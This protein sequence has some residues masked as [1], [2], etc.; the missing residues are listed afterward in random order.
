MRLQNQSLVIFLENPVRNFLSLKEQVYIFTCIYT[1]IFTPENTPHT[2]LHLVVFLNY[3]L[4]LLPYI[5]VKIYLIFYEC[6]IHHGINKEV[7]IYQ[8][9]Y[10]LIFKASLATISNAACFEYDDE[11]I[12]KTYF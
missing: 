6:I 5:H 11:F 7:F 8:A 2:L 12:Y 1:Y 4:E 3:I 10:Q 9:N